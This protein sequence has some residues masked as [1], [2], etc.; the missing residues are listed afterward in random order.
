MTETSIVF[1]LTLISELEE[2]NIAGITVRRMQDADRLRL[3][4]FRS[5]EINKD[6]LLQSISGVDS[7]RG[8]YMLSAALALGVTGI[9]KLYASNY[10]ATLSSHEEAINLNFVLKLLGDSFTS[11][12]IGF[13]EQKHYFL[14]PPCYYGSNALAIESS[15]LDLASQLMNLTRRSGDQKLKIMSEKLQYAFSTAP[16]RESRFLELSIILEMLLLPSSSSELSYRFALR[17]AKF[18]AK[19]EAADAA[20]VFKI[21]KQ[22]YR[23]RSSIVHNGYAKTLINV[24]SQTEDYVRQFLRNYLTNPERF[25]EA[26]LDEL[27]VSG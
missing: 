21:G 25:S 7:G 6:G 15:D 4:G 13:Q 9:E 26:S 12:F 1:P 27:C 5:A 20:K 14:S 8:P 16:R 19:H 18:L 11:L 22:I 24:E 3:F 17:M 2:F 10:V 23:A